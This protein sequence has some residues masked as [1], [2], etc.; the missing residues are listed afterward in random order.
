ME[1]L[2]AAEMEGRRT[3]QQGLEQVIKWLRARPLV[4][5]SLL[6]AV[7]AP[8]AVWS[9]YVIVDATRKP[10]ALS[11]WLAVVLVLAVVVEPV[12]L[13]FRR[14]A[15]L[16]SFVAVSAASLVQTVLPGSPPMMPSLVAFLFSLFAYCA[17]GR[18]QAPVLGLAVGAVG[19]GM[20][21][22]QLVLS[23]QVDL[24]GIRLIPL[25]LSLLAAVLTAWSL[26]LFR[27]I[28]LAYVAA[29]EERAVRAEADREER[30][31]RA[32]LDERARIAREMHD[33]LA[34][35]LAVIISQAQGGQYAARTDPARATET[36]ATIAEAGRQALADT[37]GLLGLL[38]ADS[39]STI[40]NGWN[41]QPTLRELPELLDRVR[42][43]G[44]T[45]DYTELGSAFPLGPAAELA[46]YR[47]VQEALTNTLKH[48]GPGAEAAVRF[49]WNDDGLTLTV[50]DTGRGCEP[51]NNGGRGLIGMRERL[52]VVGGSVAA[53]P[54]PEGGFVVRAWLPRRTA[55]EGRH[56]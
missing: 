36:L 9:I 27:R 17:Y 50:S 24:G 45:V 2:V 35:S 16:P 41:P 12:A 26:G 13:T 15:P 25:Y 29:L 38:R 1:N 37:R 54:G 53:G 10:Q 20:I 34:H 31:R 6:A 14:V 23:G 40:A 21:T 30:A 39:P 44:L 3:A 56:T 4:E 42:T 11:T 51:D 7:V 43:A 32:V 47:L 8:F 22:A 55:D 28:Q 33:V 18:R 19:A 49:D 52:A 48:A 46:L 5:D